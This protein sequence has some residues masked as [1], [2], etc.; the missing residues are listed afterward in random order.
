MTNEVSKSGLI[1]RVY[2]VVTRNWPLIAFLSSALMLAI[3]HSF[4]KFGGL[5][6]C[7]LCLK[8]REVFWVA[9]AVGLIAFGLQQTP[10]WTR[11]RQPANL[12][13]GAIFLYSAGLAAFHAGVEWKWWPGPLT[14]TGTGTVT[15]GSLEA[16]LNGTVKLKPPMCDKAAWVFLGL[17]MAG[18]N[19]LISLKLAIWGALSGL[20]KAETL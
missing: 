2:D 7:H 3:A 6:P 10:L 18:W 20:R 16:A 4:E 5:A 11:L 14:C 15:V 8:Q 13:L 19:A 9:G 12:L 17:S 1:G